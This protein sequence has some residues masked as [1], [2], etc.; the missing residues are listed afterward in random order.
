MLTSNNKP[1]EPMPEPILPI[2]EAMRASHESHLQRLVAYKQQ[3]GRLDDD[4]HHETIEELINRERLA[5][6]RYASSID[7]M[8]KVQA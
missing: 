6:S 2:L 7:H 3:G 5:L 8:L 1:E 4:P